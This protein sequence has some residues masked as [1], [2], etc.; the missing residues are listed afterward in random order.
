M[1][2]K[3][4]LLFVINMN[5]SISL[6]KEMISKVMKAPINLFFDVTPVGTIMNRFS[7]DLTT[8]DDTI[9]FEFGM[10]AENVIRICSVM[11][12]IGLTD[13]RICVI[14]PVMFSV[15]VYLYKFMIP[16]HKGMCRVESVTDSPLLN[17]LNESIAGCSTIRAF[18]KQKEF[19]TKNN[20]C[21]NKNILAN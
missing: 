3:F 8:L 16:A 20:E 7:K 9:S 10:L 14:M 19:M 17:L 15:A 13:W 1:F 18:K 2:L 4:L 5:A 6:H 11:V 21:I 12:V